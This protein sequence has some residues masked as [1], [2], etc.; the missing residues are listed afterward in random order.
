MIYDRV[1]S[2]LLGRHVADRA[3]GGWLTVALR[4]FGPTSSNFGG[5]C[6]SLARPKSRILTWPS[7]VT[8]RFSGFQVPINDTLFM[9]C[10]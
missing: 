3:Q 5:R 7:L 8:N 6:V 4:A 10:R 2:H 9:R 1:P